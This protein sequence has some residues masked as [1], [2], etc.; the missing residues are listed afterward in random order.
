MEFFDQKLG[1][2][3]PGGGAR[4]AYQVGVLK[5]ISD[6]QGKIEASPFR[7]I[8]GTS[9]G[10]INASMISSRIE[11]FHRSILNLEDVWENFSTNHIYKTE[12]LFMLKQSLHWLLTLVSG[13]VLTKNPRS[14]LNNQPLRG[15]LEKTIDFESINHNISSGVL[16][17]FILTAASYEEKQ[18]V[19]FFSTNSK[20]EDWHKVGRSGRQSKINIDHLMAS[21]ALPLIFPAIMIDGQ[22]YGD[23]AMRQETP[24][25]P[26]IRLGATNLLI[27]STESSIDDS[28]DLSRVHYPN[29]SEIGGYVLDGLFSGSLYSDLE[30]LDRINQVIA[31]ND[32]QQV[33]TK[34]KELRHID[35]LVISPSKDINEIAMNCY[36]DIP[37]SIRMLFRGIGI[38]RSNN[39]ELLSFLLFESS[40]SKSL[41]DLGFQDA[42]KRREEIKKFLEI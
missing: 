2:V 21:V 34:T 19:S 28:V 38:N 23:G 30:R 24:L 11:D 17:A 22:Y 12:K 20:V 13:G 31:Q 18:S 27:I 5:A 4:G 39:S 26:A 29:I 40:F 8:S 15:L 25:S 35:Y 32:K 6:I 10:A 41:I 36:E 16:D 9:A 7:V 3:L 33:R 1:L 14:L 37:L 42:M